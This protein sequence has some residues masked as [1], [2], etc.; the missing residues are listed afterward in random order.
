VRS[1]PGVDLGEVEG[2]R[3]EVVDE[4]TEGD[5]VG[6]A[7]REVGDRN[8]LKT[9]SNFLHCYSQGDLIG[10]ISALAFYNARVVVVNFEVVRLDPGL[11]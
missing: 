8:F 2:L 7:R 4:G 5:A 1:I 11:G 9:G 6:P 3:E 10:R